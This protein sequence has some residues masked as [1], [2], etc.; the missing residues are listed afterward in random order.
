[1]TSIDIRYCE[2]LITSAGEGLYEA[3]ARKERAASA[4]GLFE[5]FR[6]ENDTAT[7]AIKT[8]LAEKYPHIRWSESEFDIS[9]QSAAEFQGEYWV[10]DA[11]DGAVQFLQGI[12][13]YAINL[14]LIRDGKPALSF[15]YDPS[16][17]DMFHAIAG[18]G[19]FW[20]GNRIHVAR[21]KKL[22]DA[23]ISTTPPSFPAKDRELA[24]LTIAGLTHLLPRAFAVRML[25][26]ASLQLANVACGR[27][28]GYYEFG[29][30]YYNWIAGSLLVQEAGGVVTAPRGDEFTW[31]TSGI[32]AANRDIRQQ[33]QEGMQAIPYVTHS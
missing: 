9:S 31:G 23:I 14:C 8:G 1:M 19:A 3:S 13:S 20:N 4:E 26:S 33:M 11:I 2:A 25:G 32:I 6:E 15:V 5:Q 10:C 28:D 17:R 7:K 24:N 30:E 22:E 12:P 18:E 27:I 16:H 21:K 29:H